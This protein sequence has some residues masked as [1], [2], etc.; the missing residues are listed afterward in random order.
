[1]SVFRRALAIMAASLSVLGSGCAGRTQILV[2][3]WSDIGTA[4]PMGFTRVHVHIVSAGSPPFDRTFTLNQDDGMGHITRV[5]GV[6]VVAY[7]HDNNSSAPVTIDVTPMWGNATTGGDLWAQPSHHVA[8]FR[9][10]H[11]DLLPV[12]LPMSCSTNSTCNAT[13]QTCSLA[14]CERADTPLT[15]FTGAY[16]FPYG[17]GD[18]GP[19]QFCDGGLTNCSGTCADLTTSADHC[20]T[21]AHP[22]GAG[23]TCTGGM[24]V[25]A[26]GMNCDGG[27][28]DPQSDPQ[29]CGACGI[30]CVSP[31]QCIRAA[32]V[33]PAG[34]RA[35]DGGCADENNNCGACGHACLNG[36][37]VGGLC[38][39]TTG[40]TCTA[41]QYCCSP[42]TCC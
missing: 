10:G 11:S 25:C 16:P 21:C 3:V 22:C 6:V 5:P 8:H 32:C 35:C 20:G 1:M 26:T 24:C 27:C 18:S 38:R 36:T 19:G 33:C 2:W 12:Y 42:S 37:C 39:C 31:G 9:P 7:P 30:P 17:S 15:D 40:T 23:M 13:S 14:G 41:T 34:F 4:G 28:I 29:N